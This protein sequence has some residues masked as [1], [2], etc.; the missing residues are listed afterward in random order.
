LDA[1]IPVEPLDYLDKFSENCCFK[2]LG[3]IHGIPA[4]FEG[5]YQDFDLWLEYSPGQLS[6]EPMLKKM[7]GRP[8]NTISA[9]HD[10]DRIVL[11][12]DVEMRS[13]FCL[14]V[15]LDG[16]LVKMRRDKDGKITVRSV[17]GISG[18][19]GR[20]ANAVRMARFGI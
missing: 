8:T 17:E 7:F 18:K 20:R 11:A 14:D 2:I 3:H 15:V 5:G 6:E 9:L 4:T 1:L 10:N 16:A 12:N 13:K 19:T